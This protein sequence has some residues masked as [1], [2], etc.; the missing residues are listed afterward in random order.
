MR[1]CVRKRA[2]VRVHP[3]SCH[4][5]QGSLHLWIADCRCCPQN[6]LLCG[7]H[8]WFLCDGSPTSPTSSVMD[9]TD[10]KLNPAPHVLTQGWQLLSLAMSLFMPKQTVM[11]LIK[12]HL[13]RHA[14]PR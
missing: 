3:R 7:K 11:W 2:C 9:L 4:S 8:S 13:H 6:L 14:D 10:C 5:Q 1:A 12:V